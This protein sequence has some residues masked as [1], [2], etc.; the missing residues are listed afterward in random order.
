[1]Q[2]EHIE[3]TKCVVTRISCLLAKS[4]AFNAYACAIEVNCALRPDHTKERWAGCPRYIFKI[5]IC[6]KNEKI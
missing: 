5:R 4:N 6:N 1:M 3:S 2:R